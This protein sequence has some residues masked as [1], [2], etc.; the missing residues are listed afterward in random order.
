M[1]GTIRIGNHQMLTWQ[2]RAEDG[3]MVG[4]QPARGDTTSRSG[5]PKEMAQ[6]VERRE[7]LS[8]L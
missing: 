4:S 2:Q 5:A 8:S 7:I 3:G 1:A 6:D